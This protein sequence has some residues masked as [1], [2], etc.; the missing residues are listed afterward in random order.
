M[1]KCSLLL[2]LLMILSMVFSVGAYA[3]ETS[4]NYAVPFEINEDGAYYMVEQKT[5]TL[6]FAQNEHEKMYPA[7]LTKIM[8]AIIV[9]E[10]CPDLSEKVTYKL[11]IQDQ[12]YQL[13]VAAGGGLSLA[14]FSAGEE[15]SVKDLLY[16]CLLPSGNE[17]AEILADYVGGSGPAF[18]EM[19]N[20][21]AK[22]LGAFNTNFA[23]ANGLFHEN[24]YTTAYDMYLIASYAMENEAFEEI[25][26]TVTYT[27]EPTNKNENGYTWIN[28]NRMLNPQ[29]EYY[30]SIINGVKTG[31]LDE[32]GRCLITTAKKSG[33]E[34]MLV[35]M[36]AEL[37]G[38]DGKYL[39]YRADF[40]QTEQFYDWAFE[41][42]KVKTVI[43][44]GTIVYSIDLNLAKD[45]KKQ[46]QLM[47]GS[48]FSTLMPQSYNI[49]NVRAV[50]EL[51]VT[52][53]N[54]DKSI[55]AP[56]KKGDVVGELKLILSGKEI[57]RVDLLAAETVERSE[58]LYL[59]DQVKGVFSSFWFKFLF[60]FVMIFVV[61]YVI[62][63]I[64][65]NH[66]RRKYRHVRRRRRF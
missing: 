57:G 31:T 38:E 11:A 66:N 35:L 18:Y 46:L 61:L 2:A 39:S 25:V 14:G 10:N 47:S 53:L 3:D 40:Q 58:A 60:L 13:N 21:K 23:N 34:Y 44:K 24:H 32:A 15:I 28:T 36:G 65:R 33:Y 19:M 6:I 7:S 50:P 51:D 9:L 56:I 64:V 1:R 30:S 62:I 5:G 42:Y 27:S 41:N 16:A 43:E 8:T 29:S 63:M 37:Y 12:I 45:G 52:L 55:D 22:E 49:D 17:A 54:E 48:T 4:S 20:E 59:L 26:S